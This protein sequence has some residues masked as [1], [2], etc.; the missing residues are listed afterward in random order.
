VCI[1]LLTAQYLCSYYISKVYILL[2]FCQLWSFPHKTTTQWTLGLD[3]LIPVLVLYFKRSCVCL[4]VA[5]HFI[6]VK[7]NS[8]VTSY[9]TI[10][11]YICT[12]IC[13]QTD[14]GQIS[15]ISLPFPLHMRSRDVY[16]QLKYLHK[17]I[18]NLVLK[19]STG[20]PCSVYQGFKADYAR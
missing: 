8:P 20:P 10:M 17:F 19:S 3:H 1:Y 12:P 14:L 5:K 16:P 13:F 15:H 4:V 2:C 7:I 18:I 11:W 9:Y 6:C